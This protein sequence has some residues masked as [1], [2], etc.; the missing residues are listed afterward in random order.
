MSLSDVKYRLNDEH[1]AKFFQNVFAWADVQSEPGDVITD[2]DSEE[3]V[4]AKSHRLQ[5]K[6]QLRI[7]RKRLILEA[8]ESSGFKLLE[9]L[10]EHRVNE[11]DHKLIWQAKLSGDKQLEE[12]LCIERHG[13]VALF[14]AFNNQHKELASLEGELKNLQTKLKE[15]TSEDNS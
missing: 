3:V 4:E 10:L 1:L 7:A 12:V 14:N 5:S 2:N 13:I 9:A 11:I 15:Y 6:L 8:V